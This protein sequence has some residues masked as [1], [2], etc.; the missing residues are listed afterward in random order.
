MAEPPSDRILVTGALGQIGTDLVE[1]LRTRHGADSVIASDVR[2]VP[3]HPLLESGPF[4]LLSVLD[5]DGVESV[6][7]E[8]EVGEIYH[9]AAILSSTGEK[10]PE[11]CQRINVGGTI[12]VLEVA[13][14]LDLKVFSPSSIAVFGPDSPRIAPQVTPLNPT[15]TYGRT[16]VTGEVMALNYWKQYGVDIRGIRYPGLIS[17]KSP[18]GGGTTD[19]A[20]EIFHAALN[21]GHYD[22]F[23]GS[24]TRLPMMYIDDAI[25][26]TMELMNTP[27]DSI[28]I[29]RAG[30]NISGMSFSAGELADAISERVDGFTCEF[31]PDERQHYADSWP[32]D[33]DDSTAREEWDWKAE[34]D[35]GRMV[36]E[37]LDRLSNQS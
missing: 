14:K 3:G 18:A 37:M 5:G 15:T 21:E 10:K 4:R 20:V 2:E 13:K 6:V 17:W 32:D 29:S 24:E 27:I 8:E 16:K 23:V 7:R 34:Y 12:T 30:Y 22:C 35:L 11:L 28:G 19:Y 31:K 1:V 9:L 25:R 36:D 26:A 33:V